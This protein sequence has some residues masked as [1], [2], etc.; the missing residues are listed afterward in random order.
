MT[1]VNDWIEPFLSSK[2]ENSGAYYYAA[3]NFQKYQSTGARK[4]SR[5]AAD[6]RC[7]G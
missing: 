6:A 4:E 5:E 1:T 3:D 7:N 2:R